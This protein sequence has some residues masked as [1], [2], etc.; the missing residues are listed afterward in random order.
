MER[1]A[2]AG[3]RVQ[4][5]AARNA[6]FDVIVVGAGTGFCVGEYTR[7]TDNATFLGRG[8]QRP[9]FFCANT[10]FA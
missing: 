4:L 3:S 1:V 9:N 2:S 6:G 8:S 5:Q 7:E 10:S